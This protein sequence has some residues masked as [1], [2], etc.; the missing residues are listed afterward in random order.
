[1]QKK[2]EAARM[3]A[4]SVGEYS[5]TQWAWSIAYR[6]VNG[7]WKMYLISSGQKNR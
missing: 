3:T 2:I 4:D 6:K 1:M 5:S 7:E